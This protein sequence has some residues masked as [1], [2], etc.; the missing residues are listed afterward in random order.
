MSSIHLPSIFRHNSNSK[1][2]TSTSTPP[3]SL[4]SKR[5]TISSSSRSQYEETDG[6]K[7]PQRSNTLSKVKR[8]GSLLSRN[9]NNHSTNTATKRTRVDAIF[10][11]NI[12]TSQHGL[13]TSSSTQS[14]INHASSSS[15]ED[16][17]HLLT[18][19]A[20]TTSPTN[21]Y[22]NDKEE[23]L[24]SVVPPA[25]HDTIF[26]TLK[27]NQQQT[28]HVSAA[29]NEYVEQEEKDEQKR[30]STH[31]LDNSKPDL[32]QQLDNHINSTSV[33][34]ET[35]PKEEEQKEEEKEVDPSTL[36]GVSLV[37]YHL[38]MALQEADIEIENEL[39]SC[40]DQM[41]KSIRS[42]PTSTF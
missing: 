41:I 20:L 42:V 30:L 15:D 29:D 17:E 19:N 12:D 1:K 10:P 37:R 33:E 28:N 11:S 36:S 38:N 18:P 23:L 6:N 4:L 13:S 22:F 34:V 5:S 27:E 35:Q 16:D 21:M 31:L 3:P 8:F 14:I 32:S 40:R 7:S 39:K 2:E 24:T 26:V 9:K 25:V